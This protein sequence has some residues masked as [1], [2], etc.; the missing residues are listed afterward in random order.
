MPLVG[1]QS[2]AAGDAGTDQTI[3]E[4]D[5]MVDAARSCLRVR[6]VALYILRAAHVPAR[7]VGGEIAALFSFVRDRVR[8]V[9]DPVG[10]EL[11]HDALNTLRVG[12]G[13]CDD[14][15]VL[16]AS[17]LQSI[18]HKTRFKVVAL[19]LGDFHHV[20][21]DVMYRGRWVPLDAGAEHMPPGVQH[22]GVVRARV[23]GESK[24]MAE[25]GS[26][27]FRRVDQVAD[28]ASREL[29]E[30]SAR[31]ALA[32]DLVAGRISSTDLRLTRAFLRREGKFFMPAWQRH[33]LDRLAVEAQRVLQARPSLDLRGGG[34]A[35]G[36]GDGSLG[37]FFSSVWKGIKSVAESAFKVATTPIRLVTAAVT[38]E[39]V[40]SVF[41][42]HMQAVG[43]IAKVI[44]PALV[45]VP[46]IGA[47]AAAAITTGGEIIAPGEPVPAGAIA[48]S[49]IPEGETFVMQTPSVPLT[50][51]V[52]AGTAVEPVSA[53][54]SSMMIP[55]L[56]AGIPWY[57]LA[58]GLMMFMLLVA[59]R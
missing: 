56:P 47:V 50:P 17:L 53:A 44:G 2:L 3:R 45:F 42:S 39:S 25:L 31:G 8:Y 41:K 59:R 10:V 24:D 49:Q 1:R 32:A 54:A 19:R 57:V 6:A 23:Y 43:T 4:M 22:P 52:A 21:L 16:L 33:M 40:W 48:V 36:N 5:R 11:V 38:G 35:G 9:R 55:G 34:V 20:L 14:K 13:D 46:G 7:D 18:G 12:A 27:D 26:Y 51:I 37:G 30:G 29:I 15:A 28:M 58:G